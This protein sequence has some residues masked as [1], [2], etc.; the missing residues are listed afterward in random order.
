MLHTGDSHKNWVMNNL[1]NI[2][3]DECFTIS[4][5][6]VKAYLNVVK[7]VAVIIYL[8]NTFYMLTQVFVYYSLYYLQAC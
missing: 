5:A 6:D 1:E 8:Q 2:V 4:V 3:Y 7:Q